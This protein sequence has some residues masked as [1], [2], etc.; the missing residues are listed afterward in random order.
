MAFDAEPSGWFGVGYSEDGTDM[1]LPI[2]S[3]P[4]LTASEADAS[5]GDIRKVLYAFCSAM[6][7]KFASL[8]AADRPTKMNI[9]KTMGTVQGNTISVGFNFSFQLEIGD[10]DVAAE[11]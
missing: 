4:D 2:A 6:R 9:L 5:T 7:D 3:F 8:P 10:L 1:T 11:E